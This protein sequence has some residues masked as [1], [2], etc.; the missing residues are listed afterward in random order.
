GVAA[1]ME[2]H[3]LEDLEKATAVTLDQRGCLIV[4]PTKTPR[5][6][7]RRSARRVV[8]EVTGVARS[9]G[10]AV[11]GSRPI[12]AFEAGPLALLGTVCVALAA[13]GFY[14]PWLLGWPIAAFV[15]WAGIT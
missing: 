1:T 14:S 4:T 10:A 8:R 3:F 7:T 6:R 11:T 15:L 9:V 13:V 12:E 2:A 5:G